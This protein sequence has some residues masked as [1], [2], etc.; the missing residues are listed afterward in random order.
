MGSSE[1]ELRGAALVGRE[2]ECG[3][4][5]R[6]LGRVSQGESGSLVLRAEAGMGKTALL[7]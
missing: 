5:D 2:P 4:I 6:L 7:G 3:A 1:F